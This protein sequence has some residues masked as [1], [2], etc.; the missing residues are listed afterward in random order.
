MRHL[1]SSMVSLLFFCE[2]VARLRKKDPWW[3]ISEVRSAAD[4][5]V[6]PVDTPAFAAEEAREDRGEDRVLA[7]GQEARGAEPQE[8]DAWDSTQPRHTSLRCRPLPRED[9][10]L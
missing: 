5:Q 6:D 2:E 8:A 3:S 1:A 10:A 4:A 9:L 7:G